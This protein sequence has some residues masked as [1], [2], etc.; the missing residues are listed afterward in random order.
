LGLVPPPSNPPLHV[1]DFQNQ[2]I[3]LH[4]MIQA[5]PCLSSF[6]PSF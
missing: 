4:L 5:L 2:T 6:L 3:P 1:D